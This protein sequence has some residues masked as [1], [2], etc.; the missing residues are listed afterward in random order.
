MNRLWIRFLSLGLDIRFQSPLLQNCVNE[1]VCF[2]LANTYHMVCANWNLRSEIWCFGILWLECYR[3]MIYLYFLYPSSLHPL[4]SFVGAHDFT[5]ILICSFSRDQMNSVVSAF[6]Q[7]MKKTQSI[8]N[9]DEERV[10]QL[11]LFSWVQRC[12]TLIPF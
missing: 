12:T 5:N 2:K 1:V 3:K 8:I 7:R 4:P 10:R 9:L 11:F 6:L